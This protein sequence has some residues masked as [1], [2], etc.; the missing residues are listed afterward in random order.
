M[1]VK[2]VLVYR[3]VGSLISVLFSLIP[4]VFFSLVSL[5]LSEIGADFG[6]CCDLSGVVDSW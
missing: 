3:L 5:I 1:G 2:F 4:F 6:V